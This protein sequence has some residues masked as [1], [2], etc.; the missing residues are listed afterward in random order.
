MNNK[1]KE[2]VYNIFACISFIIFIWFIFSWFEVLVQNTRPYP[3]YHEWNM[4]TIYVTIKTIL[5]I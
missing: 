5:G 3:T 1:L 4:F 2:T